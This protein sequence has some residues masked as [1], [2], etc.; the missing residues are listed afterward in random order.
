MTKKFQDYRKLTDK[1]KE[2]FE[3]FITDKTIPLEVRW[4]T[5]EEA[6]E[7]LS[8][9]E[10]YSDPYEGLDDLINNGADGDDREFWHDAYYFDRHSHHDMMD[11]VWEIE[12]G[13][14]DEFMKDWECFKDPTILNQVKEKLMEHNMKS[15]NI[16]W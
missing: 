14:L 9:E 10:D 4:K 16:D 7:E 12:T 13:H 2:D 3:A 6:P 5:F 11:L 8:P 15:F 1:L